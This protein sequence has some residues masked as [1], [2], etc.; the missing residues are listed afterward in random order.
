MSGGA[1]LVLGVLLGLACWGGY[2]LLNPKCTDCGGRRP[3]WHLVAIGLVLGLVA[4][5][6]IT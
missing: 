3:G 5:L 1:G 4:G 6:A 2:L